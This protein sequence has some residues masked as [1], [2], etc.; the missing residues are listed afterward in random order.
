MQH[1]IRHLRRSDPVLGAIIDRVGTYAIQ[2]RDPEFGTLVRSI[3]YQ[4]LSGK[5]A[6]V[7]LQRLIAALDN[8]VTPEKILK[9]RPARM[10]KLGL[11]AAKT[12][13]IRDLARQTRDGALVFEQLSG[14]SDDEVITV[15]TQVKEI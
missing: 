1:A 4:Q 6:S 14:M 15:L 12:D 9:L 2:Y 11:S 10:R 8:E 3:V 7:I 13:Y 5:V